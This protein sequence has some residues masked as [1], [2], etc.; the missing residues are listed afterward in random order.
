MNCRILPSLA[1]ALMIASTAAA[2]EKV[3]NVT[4]T[5]DGNADKVT[6]SDLQSP[7]KVKRT[8]AIV[9]NVSCVAGV[10]CSSISG[11]V[12]V[13]DPNANN[14]VAATDPMTVVTTQNGDVKLSVKG[15]AV[16]EARLG[17]VATLEILSGATVI[18]S[19]TLVEDDT[20]ADAPSAAAVSTTN[21]LVTA[22]CVDRF[23]KE[24]NG[25]TSY[26]R[27]GNEATFVILPTGLVSVRPPQ[28]IDE[29]DVIHIIVVANRAL[30][31]RLR[32]YRKSAFRTPNQLRIMGEGTNVPI[33][34][35]AGVRTSCVSADVRLGDFQPGR[36]EVEIAVLET[37]NSSTVV[38]SF[39]FGV[40]SLFTGAFGLGPMHSWLKSPSFGLLAPAAAGSDSII[41]R[42]E[43]RTSRV[44]YVLSYTHFMW[45]KRDEEKDY[46]RFR[47]RVNPMI[48]VTL[49]DLKNNAIVGLSVDA[50][51]GMFVQGG[52]HGARIAELDST[53]ALS[54]G[55]TFAGPASKLPIA[56][57]WRFGA[58]VGVSLDIRAAAKLFSTAI[59]AAGGGAGH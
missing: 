18:G 16:P 44:L 46:E 12:I 14:A 35:Q 45:G 59:S 47:E 54:P 40:N 48:G 53:A 32:V 37:D 4:V 2:Q 13:R 1:A 26:D 19:Y 34:L 23:V 17:T 52:I 21:G 43:G 20:P 33:N 5:H 9:V 55:K 58:F 25:Q 56:H 38:G 57:E 29:N 42:T 7:A 41:T 27:Q 28:T 22:D 39:D 10:T 15:E 8:D 30:I 51:N 49:N 31:P 36:G 24:S 11:R 6:K 50:G 3:F